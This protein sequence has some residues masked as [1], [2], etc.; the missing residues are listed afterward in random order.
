VV[1]FSNNELTGRSRTHLVELADPPCLLHRD[2]VAPFQAL[3]A[4]AKRAGIEL[5]PIS[6]F[7]DFDRQLAIWNGKA[8]GERELRGVDGTLVDALTLDEEARVAAIL[9]WSTLPGASRHHWGTDFD[10]IDAAAMP[11]GYRVQL[12]P[13]EYAPGGVFARLND[14]LD[15]HAAHYGF[16]RPYATWRGGV[17]PEPWHLSHAA[18]SQAAVAQYS[19]D[20]LREALQA[21]PVAAHAAID[22]RLPEILARYVLNVD[23]PPGD[24]LNAGAA[25]TPV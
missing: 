16:Y 4:A 3:R 7:R 11:A 20:A 17:Q 22:R 1:L 18:V 19:A 5:V 2:V 10:A 21:A 23:A 14:W 8:S 24:A 9:H 13:E 6:S 12:V 15:R 25:A